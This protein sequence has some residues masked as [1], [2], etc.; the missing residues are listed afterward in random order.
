M[1]GRGVSGGVWGTATTSCYEGLGQ[2]TKAIDHHEQQLSITEEVGDR[3]GQ[4]YAFN[5]LGNA[6]ANNGDDVGAPRVLLCGLAVWQR[7]EEDVGAHDDRRVSL[8]E[9]QQRTYRLLQDVL[10]RQEG[11]A[12]WALGVAA[13]GKARALAYRLGAVG[14]SHGGGGDSEDGEQLADRPYEDVCESH[15]DSHTS[16]YGR[17]TSGDCSTAHAPSHV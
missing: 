10:M 1:W 16:S 9:K 7:I 6:L 13:E 15:H 5:N 11:Q 2:Y 4:G 17:W 14:E 8:F 3:V 12:G